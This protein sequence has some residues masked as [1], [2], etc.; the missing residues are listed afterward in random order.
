MPG[1]TSADDKSK[2]SKI[3]DIGIRILSIRVWR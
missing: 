3:F 1:R 2:A